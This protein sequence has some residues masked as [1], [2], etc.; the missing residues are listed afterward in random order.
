[1]QDPKGKEGS[2]EEMAEGVKCSHAER[3]GKPEYRRQWNK[4]PAAP[5]IS[6]FSSKL[7]KF[8]YNNCS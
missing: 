7:Q 2:K 8:P 1:M 5:T 6:G 4:P 3:L